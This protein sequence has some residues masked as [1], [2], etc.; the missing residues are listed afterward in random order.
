MRIYNKLVRDNIPS[1]IRENGEM[2]HISILNDKDYF[3]KLKSKLMEETNEF[4]ASEELTELADILEV[5]DFLARAKGSTLDE[6][7]EIKKQKSLKNGGFE[8]KVF[9][10]FVESFGK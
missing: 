2:P 8:K 1:I 9:L 7:F 10:E 3:E 5:V 6:I 4:M